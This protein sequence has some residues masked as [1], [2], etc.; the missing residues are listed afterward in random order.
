MTGTIRRIAGSCCVVAGAGLLLYAASVTARG[1]IWQER[2]A[3]QFSRQVAATPAPVP[4]GQVAPP[5]RG[6]ALA[7]LRVPRLGID[8]V[9]AEGTDARSLSLGAGHLEDSALPGQPDNCII[10]GHRDGPFGRLRSARAG[11]LVEI[12]DGVRRH[13]YEIVERRVVRK[14]DVRDL[15]P[16]ARPILTLVT[17]YPIDHL[18]PAPRRL[19]VRGELREGDVTA[20]PPGATARRSCSSR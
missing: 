7:R 3:A 9:V 4:T 12:S 16:A 8:V 2:H 13:R 19:V 14:D 5:R 20:G 17:C 18:G 11:D 10:A 15:A 6:E 1:A